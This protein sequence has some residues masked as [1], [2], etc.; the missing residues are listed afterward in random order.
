ME[1]CDAVDFELK[2]SRLHTIHSLD[3]LLAY[4]KPVTNVVIK[5]A[6]LS[7]LG[8]RWKHI[9]CDMFL[10]IACVIGRYNIISHGSFYSRVWCNIEFPSRLFANQDMTRQLVVIR[11]LSQQS[12]PPSTP[13]FICGRYNALMLR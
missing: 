13:C 4:F 12:L 1:P 3:T 5:A 11:S 9:Q 10:S 8:F 7:Y 2:V 6:D